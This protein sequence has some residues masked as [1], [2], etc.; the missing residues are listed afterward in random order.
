VAWYQYS[1]KS[2]SEEAR[3]A[4]I[5][6]DLPKTYPQ[7]K[8]EHQKILSHEVISPPD[9]ERVVVE[10]P[11]PAVLER[12]ENSLNGQGQTAPSHGFSAEYEEENEAGSKQA[13]LDDRHKLDASQGNGVSE[14]IDRERTASVKEASEKMIEQH[15]IP[16]PKYEKD[17]LINKGLPKKGPQKFPS[18]G[19]FAALD[20][21]AEVL[22]DIVHIPF[23]EATSDVILVGWEDQWFADAVLDIPRWGKIN[24]T[25]I[26]FVYTCKNL[27]LIAFEA[28]DANP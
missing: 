19:E 25:K 3:E 27:S 9:E 28:S 18:Y 4:I 26:D 13:V 15:L 6:S 24:E 23:E 12:A 22:P 1:G 10:K 21:N 14:P 7:E 17:T 8:A 16:A 20:E 11:E 2:L 5:D